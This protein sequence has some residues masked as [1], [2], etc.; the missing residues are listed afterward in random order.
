MNVP[1]VK[2]GKAAK[3]GS[4]RVIRFLMH[5]VE[6]ML[7]MGAGMV[8]FHVLFRKASSGSDATLHQLGMALFMLVPMFGWMLIRGHGWRHSA[9]MAAAMLGPMAAIIAVC[10][11]IAGSYPP[12]LTYLHYPAMCLG[13]LGAMLYRRDHYL[14][15]G[16]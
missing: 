4:I 14:R 8:V 13:M 11:I 15:H 1:K 5:L 10:W 16:S 6:M 2:E 7:A 3:T 9:E 12:W